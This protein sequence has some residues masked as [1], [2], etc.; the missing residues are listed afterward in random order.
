MK[1]CLIHSR[2]VRVHLENLSDSSLLLRGGILEG[3]IIVN[4]MIEHI[5]TG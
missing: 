5:Q 2:P 1:D 4:D 3:F